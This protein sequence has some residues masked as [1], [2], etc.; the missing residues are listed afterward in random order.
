MKML[1]DKVQITITKSNKEIRRACMKED[2]SRE[3]NFKTNR[4]F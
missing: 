3:R 1:Q 4:P 2:C